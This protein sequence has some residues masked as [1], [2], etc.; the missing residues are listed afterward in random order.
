MRSNSVKK[1]FAG[2]LIVI[3][4]GGVYQY[5]R[6]LPPATVNFNTVPLPKS[7]VVA[8]PWPASAQAALGAKDYGL[9]ENHGND[10]PRPIAS[11]AKVITALAVLKAKPI[12]AGGSGPTITLDQTDLDYFNYYYSHDGSVANVSV[13]EQI[14]EYKMLQALLIP[15]ANNIGDSLARWAFGSTQAYIVYAN[16]MIKSLGLSHTT[17]GNTNGFD[18]TTV[19]TAGDLVKLGLVAINSPVIAGIVDQRSAT[20]PVQG[21]VHNVNFLLDS[22]GING[23]K[24]GNTDKAGGCYLFSFENEIL[25]KKIVFVGAIVGSADLSS[26]L[27]DGGSLARSAYKGMS[28]TAALSNGQTIGTIDSAWGRSAEIKAKDVSVTYWKSQPPVVSLTPVKIS[29]PSAAGAIVGTAT[30]RNSGQ[31]TT[32]SLYTSNAIPGPSWHWRLFRR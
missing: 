6:P 21:L 14:T 17:V 11:V 2:L 32:S 13:G 4:I 10:T 29:L 23:I 24:T 15:S 1:L 12:A 25:N 8:L 5:F 30:V 28:Q 3:L 16:Q 26:A 18:D 22:Y 7:L 9:L 19:S 20:I 31:T 27:N